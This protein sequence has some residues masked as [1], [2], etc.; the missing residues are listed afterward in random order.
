MS[1]EIW[2]P[3]KQEGPL[4]CESMLSGRGKGDEVERDNEG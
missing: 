4:G 1:E 3:V 2:L